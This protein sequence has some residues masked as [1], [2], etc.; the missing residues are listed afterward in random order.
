[1]DCNDLQIEAHV[2]L[3]SENPCSEI[4]VLTTHARPLLIGRS[5]TPQGA[6]VH[7]CYFAARGNVEGFTIR[8]PT[9]FSRSSHTIYSQADRTSV[10]GG[11]HPGLAAVVLFC[12]GG[13]K[14]C[15]CDFD[16]Y[17]RGPAE[18]APAR[19]QVSKTALTITD[20]ERWQYAHHAGHGRAQVRSRSPNNQPRCVGFGGLAILL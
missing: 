6:T 17:A 4:E 12:C 13:L 18:D 7:M 15:D 1:M 3:C 5:R 9:C 10:P 14:N 19:Q 20:P 16:S 11:L 2:C 8:T